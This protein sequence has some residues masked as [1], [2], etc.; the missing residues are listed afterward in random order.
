MDF[1][2]K[3]KELETSDTRHKPP[4]GRKGQLGRKLFVDVTGDEVIRGIK[5][6]GTEGPM[7]LE[8]QCC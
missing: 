3:F 8:A 5:P 4:Q 1:W 6:I 2:A 7:G